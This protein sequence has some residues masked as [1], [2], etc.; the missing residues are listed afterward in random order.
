MGT[1]RGH[2]PLLERTTVSAKER[3]GYGELKLHIPWFDEECSKFF[4]RRKHDKP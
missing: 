3:F 1:S 2:G 4:D